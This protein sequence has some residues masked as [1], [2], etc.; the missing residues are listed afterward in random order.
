MNDLVQM[1]RARAEFEGILASVCQALRKDALPRAHLHDV[2]MR[3]GVLH[4]VWLEG[5]YDLEVQI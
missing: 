5:I 3:Q 4:I 1:L 2:Y